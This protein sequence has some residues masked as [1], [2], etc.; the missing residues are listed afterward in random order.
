MQIATDD[1]GAPPSLLNRFETGL[2]VIVSAFM[3]VLPMIA[4]AARAITGDSLSGTILFVQ[5]LTLWAGF[6]GAMIATGARAHLALATT[7]FLP[8]GRPREAARF[9]ANTVAGAVVAL[10]GYAAIVMIAANR[11]SGERLFHVMPSWWSELI[12][13]LT[14]A[15]MAVRSAYLAHEKWLFRGVSLGIIALTFLLDLT[16]DSASWVTWPCLLAII[17][18]VL[19]GAPVYVGMAG[20]A[21]TFFFVDGVSIAAVPTEIFRLVASPT[22]PA[23]PLLTLCGFVLAEGGAST[24]LVRAA[25]A[26]VGSLPGGIA[27]MVVIVCA[28][29]TTLTGGSGVTIIAL[30]GLVLPVL[31]KE[32]YP[33]GFSLGLVTAAGSLGLLLPP[34]LPVILYSVVAETSADK[35]FLAGFLPGL[36]LIVLVM[37]Y[38]VYIGVKHKTPRHPFSFGEAKSALWDAKWELAIPA[39]LLFGI[40]GG[41]TTIVEASAIAA[42]MAIVVECLVFKDLSVKKDLPR[43]ITHSGRLMGAVLI[44]LGAAMGLTSYLVDAQVPTAL[45]GWVKTHV[46]SPYVFLFALNLILLVLGSVLEIYS[47]IVI[48]APLIVP[49]AAAFGIDPVHMGIIFLSNLELGFLFPP[50]GLNLLLS[51]SRFRTPL[52]RVYKVTTP[53]LLI[54]AAGVLAITY[55]PWMSIGFMEKVRAKPAPVVEEQ[56]A[57]APQ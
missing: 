49:M 23:I 56:P 3:V 51:A 35:I 20:I 28:L 52:P 1:A 42:F 30:G 21:M 13:P 26:I 41:K 36:L 44:V 5:H 24:R 17:G 53:F 10:L 32:G 55:M 14:L 54:M 15:I 27:I 16:A 9:I 11:E 33:E 40:F 38:G 57:S 25:R 45:L 29:F 4:T 39:V 19:L 12:M 18:A 37:A 47:A 48:L 46:S 22:L 34:S 7:E 6:G 43:V 8:E 31:V 50:V 2:I